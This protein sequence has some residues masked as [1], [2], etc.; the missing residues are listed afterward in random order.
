VQTLGDIAL[1]YV[2]SRNGYALSNPNRWGYERN[3]MYVMSITSTMECSV[4]SWDDKE[5][6]K[7]IT[8]PTH[9]SPGRSPRMIDWCFR[10]LRYEVDYSLVE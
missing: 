3:S 8:L 7:Y 6:Q 2:K 10:H 4:H 5:L 1:F 9:A